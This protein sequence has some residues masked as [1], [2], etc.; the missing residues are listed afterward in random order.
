M[1]EEKDFVL[2]F[3][4]A[5]LSAALLLRGKPSVES[6]L[7]ETL[8]LGERG[9][10]LI[11]APGELSCGSIQLSFIQPGPGEAA[12]TDAS[13]PSRDARRD[14]EDVCQGRNSTPGVPKNYAATKGNIH[15]P[16]R[17]VS[18]LRNLTPGKRT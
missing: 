8:S 4:K 5:E 3:Q 1:S 7:T 9:E 13:Q 6:L 15:A 12:S 2:L 18:N 14:E 17:K 16:N 10:K 11:I